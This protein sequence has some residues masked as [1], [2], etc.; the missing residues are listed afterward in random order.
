MKANRKSLI[1]WSICMVLFVLSGMSKYTTYSSGGA[2]S[3]ALAEMPHSMR[4]LLG[5]G[6]FNVSKMSGFFA[7]LFPYIEVTVAV[8]AVLLG[9]HI[10]AKEERDKTTEFLMVK[11]VS[12]SS[13]MTSKFLAAL[14]NIIVINVVTLISSIIFVGAFNKGKDITS[15]IIVFLLSLFIVQLIFVSLGSL[16]S[17]ILKKP[18]TAGSWATFILFGGFIIAKI[19]DLAEN[20]EFLNV[21]SPFKYFSYEDIV[22]GDGLN[23]IV[24]ILSLVMV[25]VFSTLSYFFYQKRDLN[26]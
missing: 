25:A 14:A 20:L 10:L 11:P 5:M 22:N 13:I 3:E 1:I 6:T 19:T 7:F 24:V 8:H 26:V 17:A 18:K 23:F 21:F 16:F 9:S 2:A 12:R 4:A 15:E